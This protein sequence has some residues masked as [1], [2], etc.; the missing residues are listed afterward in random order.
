MFYVDMHAA[1]YI[2][3]DW[4]EIDELENYYVAFFLDLN[5]LNPNL[6]QYFLISI[7]NWWW[8]SSIYWFKSNL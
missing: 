1:R 8:D 2:I 3:D 7:W 6:I 4:F 5:Y